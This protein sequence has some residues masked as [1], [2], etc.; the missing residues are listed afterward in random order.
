M[1]ELKP[2]P[3][4]RGDIVRN[5]YAG[6]RNPSKYLLYLGKSTIRQG[7][8]SHPG[9]DCLNFYGERVQLFRDGGDI[10]SDCTLEKVGHMQEFDRFLAALKRLR[11]MEQEANP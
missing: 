9:Y 6:D 10:C 5:I 11:N 3:F 1:E 7:R 8:Y 2:C 4:K